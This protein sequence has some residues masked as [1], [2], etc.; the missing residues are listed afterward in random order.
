MDDYED[1]QDNR[2]QTNTSSV[3]S[4]QNVFG[5]IEDMDDIPSS[6]KAEELN[7]D[8]PVPDITPSNR[9]I[10]ELR[11]VDQ[12]TGTRKRIPLSTMGSNVAKSVRI[13]SDNYPSRKDGSRSNRSATSYKPKHPDNILLS[14]V[15]KNLS[16]SERLYNIRE[17]FKRLQGENKD[18]EIP[19]SSDPDALERMYL[20]AARTIHYNST[21]QSWILYMG[22]GYA[23]FQAL[24]AWMG[25][26]LPAE[27]VPI[28]L[29]V[30]TH[31]PKLLKELGDPGGVSFGSTWSPWVKLIVIIIIHSIIFIIIVKMTGDVNSARS[32]QYL[33]CR[34][35]FMGG[36]SK[37]NEAEADLATNNL[38]GMLGNLIGGGGGGLGNML[39]GL[40][41][42]FMGGN[43]SMQNIDLN[44]VPEPIDDDTDN[45]DNA[46]KSTRNTPFD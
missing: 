28:Q 25:F 13:M 6:T 35:G 19:D 39:S 30:M 3:S 11:K 14:R 36:Q 8:E 5:N 42:N 15:N 43:S 38:G 45:N 16:K 41:G 33:I 1:N 12:I 32:A 18:V 44:N 37:G 21:S 46:N 34:T 10:D 7:S 20:E 22:A 9:L 26:S 31:Y 23:I 24:L 17:K 2:S 4:K 27:F 29:E 40:L